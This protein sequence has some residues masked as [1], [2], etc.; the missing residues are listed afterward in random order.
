MITPLLIKSLN[1]LFIIVYVRATLHLDKAT[2][3][4][5]TIPTTVSKRVETV[6]KSVR[7]MSKRLR[8]MSKGF[9]AMSKSTIAM[10]TTLTAQA[11]AT[12]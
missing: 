3:V 8:A 9:T 2:K 10:N 1:K 12:Q 11:E 7:V 5:S 4:F 6:S